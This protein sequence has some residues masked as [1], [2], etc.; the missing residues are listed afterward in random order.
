[1]SDNEIK[2]EAV[3]KEINVTETVLD[4]KKGKKKFSI[5]LV[6]PNDDAK[7][8][9]EGKTNTLANNNNNLITFSKNT[10]RKKDGLKTVLKDVNNDLE[11][12]NNDLRKS[13]KTFSSPPNKKVSSAARNKNQFL[14]ENRQ[15]TSSRTKNQYMEENKYP[16]P[17]NN[18]KRELLRYNNEFLQSNKAHYPFEAKNEKLFFLEKENRRLKE[19]NERLENELEDYKKYLDNMLQEKK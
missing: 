3:T 6:S 12:I 19:H 4:T 2:S 14:E 16:K 11:V 7:L 13:L 1:M 15:T 9:I 18:D 5:L 8:E 17:N 10:K